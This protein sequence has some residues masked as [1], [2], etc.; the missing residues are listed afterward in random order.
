MTQ[1][2]TATEK[3][4]AHV[5]KP[6]YI[7]SF[8]MTVVRDCFYDANNPAEYEKRDKLITEELMTLLGFWL[9]C[10]EPKFSYP[11]SFEALYAMMIEAEELMNEMHKASYEL[12]IAEMREM[13][14]SA[15]NT[16]HVHPSIRL[17]EEA[18]AQSIQEAIYY[19]GD[20][21]YD[22]EYIHFLG[23]KYKY[24]KD[25]LLQNKSFDV[26]EAGSI[27]LAIKELLRKKTDVLCFP[28]RSLDF[29][30]LGYEDDEEFKMAMEFATYM[31]LIPPFDDNSSESE[32]SDALHSFCDSLVRLFGRQDL[33]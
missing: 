2:E 14:D 19:C 28:D 7:Y 20:Y 12:V 21:A 22:Y 33:S 10:P 18:K 15:S 17:S 31:E 29:K 30:Q 13:L 11:D 32:V 24:D 9:Q 8:L 5:H 6:G 3:I 16:Q 4:K 25:W 23:K 27:A 1:L 26:D